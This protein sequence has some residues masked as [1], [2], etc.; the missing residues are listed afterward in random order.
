MSNSS[1]SFLSSL[2]DFIASLFGRKRPT[3]PQQPQVPNVPAD[4]P[5]E[6]AQ[7]TVSKVLVI[8]YNPV[9]DAASW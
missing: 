6:P 9:M 5:N 1:K 2:W 3:A 4:D 8:V 7:I